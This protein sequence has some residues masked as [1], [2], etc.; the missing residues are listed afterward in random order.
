MSCVLCVVC[1][2]WCV[3]CCVLCVV[4]F[5]LCLVC[6]VSL[7]FGSWV[8]CF[9]SGL[10]YCVLCVVCCVWCVMCCVLCVVSSVLCVAC[11][12][13]CLT[14][15]LTSTWTHRATKMD[16][17]HARGKVMCLLLRGP[18]RKG[19]RQE[20]F[21]ALMHDTSYDLG[22]GVC[23][24]DDGRYIALSWKH[25]DLAFKRMKEE[26]RATNLTKSMRSELLL[27]YRAEIAD[28]QFLELKIK[29]CVTEYLDGIA[30]KK[31]KPK[32]NQP[33]P[34][35]KNAPKPMPILAC[36]QV[37]THIASFFAWDELGLT[38]DSPLAVGEEP[39]HNDEHGKWIMGT[40]TSLNKNKHNVKYYTCQFH[41]PAPRTF[42]YNSA[43]T[44]KAIRNLAELRA[45]GTTPS[46]D[47]EKGSDSDSVGVSNNDS[48]DED[49]DVLVLKTKTPRLK[50]VGNKGP[51]TT[52]AMPVIKANDCVTKYDAGVWVDGRVIYSKPVRDGGTFGC[53]MAYTV[54]FENNQKVVCSLKTTE[55][56]FL[57]YQLREKDL[58]VEW[59]EDMQLR[60][61]SKC[62]APPF[63][64]E[65]S[66]TW[67][68][69]PKLV[70]Y[71][72]GL[73]E[74]GLKFPCGYMWYV[75]HDVIQSYLER[76]QAWKESVNLHDRKLVA[77]AKDE[78][79]TMGALARSA[80]EDTLSD[81]DAPEQKLSK[82]ANNSKGILLVYCMCSKMIWAV[83][84]LNLYQHRHPFKSCLRVPT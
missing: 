80:G 49:E 63:L 15:L 27:R 18:K 20:E 66:N 2:V 37:G 48:L 58:Y 56:M 24:M 81:D 29:A 39:L 35:S 47:G 30:A 10:V 14:A 31:Q 64:K 74:F 61:L 38:P 84:R 57:T 40:V 79:S 55:E 73:H 51:L 13:L 82:G 1:C 83:T 28:S 72:Q 78:V 32:K 23:M 67:L 77:Y 6:Y 3:V 46:E 68:R 12:V 7:P 60:S 41:T 26:D 16:G 19:Q 33:R 50:S 5:V 36:V 21:G 9:V 53:K 42:E 59:T 8:L 34:A 4:S 45:M 75:K 43:E 22:H 52:H 71:H 62:L 44:Q 17:H 70:K 65:G 54:E 11:C 25:V 76:S 69:I